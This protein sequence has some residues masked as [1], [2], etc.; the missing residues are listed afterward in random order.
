M[1]ALTQGHCWRSLALLKGASGCIFLELLNGKLR[2]VVIKWYHKR[3]WI[4]EP[5]QIWSNMA[6]LIF[7]TFSLFPIW[8]WNL[9]SAQCV[10]LPGNHSFN[11]FTV[12][13][14]YTTLLT[15]ETLHSAAVFRFSINHGYL[16]FSPQLINT[17]ECNS[18]RSTSGFL[19]TC[20]SSS[21]PH[22]LA[23]NKPHHKFCGWTQVGGWRV[24]QGHTSHREP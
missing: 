19:V 11:T 1:R 17:N 20:T 16:S 3:S 14:T 23:D 8:H 10:A 12:H 6:S 18:Q 7:L 22:P 21:H 24:F 2:C 13:T 9:L 15:L 4:I 5:K